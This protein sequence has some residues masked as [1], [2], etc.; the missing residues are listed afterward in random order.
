MKVIIVGARL[1]GVTTAYVLGRRGHDVTVIDR[2]EGPSRDTSLANAALLTP[3][4]AEPWNA[5]GSWRVLLGS[6]GRPNAPLQLRLRTL[7]A[8]MGWGAGFLRNSRTAS[9]QRNVLRNL[10]LALYSLEIMQSLRQE[11][12]IE[13]GRATLGTLRVFRDQAVLDHA[14]RAADRLVGEGL[15]FR[16]LSPLEAVELEPALAPI[17]THLAGALHCEADETGDAYRF[18]VALAD[19]ARKHG[20]GFRFGTDVL[21]L[22]RSKRASRHTSQTSLA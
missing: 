18:C 3:S 15:S 8:L 1:M 2:E 14:S 20:V 17:A 12:G 22:L 5:P 4:M 6:L 9:F 21:S 10:R 13:Y 7:P 16:R 19:Q 11:T